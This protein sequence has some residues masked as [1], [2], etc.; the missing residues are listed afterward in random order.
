MV[1]KVYKVVVRKDF[2]Y[3]KINCPKC[4]DEVRAH[5]KK[6]CKI[7]YELYHVPD[8]KGVKND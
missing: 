6:Q 1:V 5:S 3:Y 8:C 2:S 4:N 7:N